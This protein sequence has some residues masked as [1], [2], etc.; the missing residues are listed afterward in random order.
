M[1]VS[2]ALKS[3]GSSEPAAADGV[4]DDEDEEESE[5]EA[6]RAALPPFLYVGVVLLK[7]RVAG[8]LYV[9]DATRAEGLEIAIVSV[10]HSLRSEGWME[11]DTGSYIVSQPQLLA[12]AG[13]N[14]GVVLIVLLALLW[15]VRCF[16]VATS[17]PRKAEC[18]KVLVTSAGSAAM[19]RHNP[20]LVPATQRHR[21]IGKRSTCPAIA[22]M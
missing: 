6:S 4:A 20:V 15:M 13:A 14:K 16:P 5:R 1:S 8:T 22:N 9:V 11:S 7:K 2:K 19:P 18:G 17:K 12:T 3:K 21:W 10:V